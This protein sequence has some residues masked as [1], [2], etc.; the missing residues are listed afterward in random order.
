[1]EPEISNEQVK[2]FALLKSFIY[3]NVEHLDRQGKN[4]AISLMVVSENTEDGS[5]SVVQLELDC[6]FNKEP[7]DISQS[8]SAYRV[9]AGDRDNYVVRD[10]TNWHYLK[11]IK[12]AVSRYMQDDLVADGRTRTG[13]RVEAY[14]FVK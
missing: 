10:I 13:I 8:G 2:K 7:S 12:K 11:D 9:I 14:P 6:K 5:F 3:I 4:I 1:M